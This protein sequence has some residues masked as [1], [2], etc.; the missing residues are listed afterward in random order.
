[1]KCNPSGHLNGV[2]CS[3]FI[4]EFCKHLLNIALVTPIN[5]HISI[6]KLFSILMNIICFRLIA[7]FS[8][9]FNNDNNINYTIDCITV[10]P[11]SGQHKTNTK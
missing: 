1:M 5:A 6:N 4:F 3:Q 10:N 2:F 7:N 11:L 9:Y 8:V